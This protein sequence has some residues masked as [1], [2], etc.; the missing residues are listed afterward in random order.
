MR[1]LLLLLL[2]SFLRGTAAF[3]GP[4]EPSPSCLP[5]KCGDLNISYPFWLDEPGGGSRCGPPP[6]Q[7]KCNSSGA[8]LSFS[9]FEAFRVV[10]IFPHNSSFHVVDDNLPLETGCPAPFFN[11]SLGIGVGS[12]MGPFDISTTNYE[13]LFLSSCTEPPPVVPPGFRSLPCSGNLSFVSQ[14]GERKYGSHLDQDGIPPSCVLSVVPTLGNGDDHITRMKDGFLLKWIGLS[15]DCPTCIASGGEC[16]YGNNGV[17]FACKCSD[18]MHR[19]KCADSKA[20]EIGMA[21]GDP[22]FCAIGGATLNWSPI[23]RSNHLTAATKQAGQRR[24]GVKVARQFQHCD[25][26]ICG[27]KRWCLVLRHVASL[28]FAQHRRRRCLRPSSRRS[29]IA[30][31]APPLVELD[32]HLLAMIPRAVALL[33]S[34]LLWCRWRQ[35]PLRTVVPL[36]L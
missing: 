34:S 9:S 35:S 31:A 3:D 23:R 12:G 10:S 30:V 36:G 19:D 26:N 20:R 32:P 8:F 18:G 28:L 1:L 5:Q 25:D 15:M 33:R 17:G 13:L 7:V 16:M 11:I 22:R 6:F 4:A 21:V 24:S 27:L 2:A 29:S 14:G